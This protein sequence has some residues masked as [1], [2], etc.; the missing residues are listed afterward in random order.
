M[1]EIEVP[2][3]VQ[4]QL[5]EFEKII[6]KLEEA[7]EPFLGITG[8]DMEQLEP[9]EAAQLQLTLGE[10]AGQ[11][12]K[13]YLLSVGIDPREHP[14]EKETERLTQWAKRLA[15]AASKKEA[16]ESQRGLALNIGAANRF[17]EHA[18]PELSKEQK[19]QLREVGKAAKKENKAVHGDKASKQKGAAAGSASAEDFLASVF[20]RQEEAGAPAKRGATGSSPDAGKAK[21]ARK[22][23]K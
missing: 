13:L 19:Q 2:E 5:D 21:K 1:A 3:E 14:I 6:G 16:S 10:A 18:I 22:S 15:K 17:I 7:L 20:G 8:K 12:F 4:A 23:K 9:L 11:L